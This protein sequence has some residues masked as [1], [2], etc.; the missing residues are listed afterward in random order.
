MELIK[1]WC[2]KRKWGKAYAWMDESARV[3]EG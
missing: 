3:S 2:Y 1:V